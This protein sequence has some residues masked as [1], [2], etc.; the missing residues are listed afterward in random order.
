MTGQEIVDK[1]KFYTDYPANAS[2]SEA[3]AMANEVYNEILRDRDWAFLNKTH[4][5]TVP[6]VL[7]YSVDL[8]TDF[9][10]TVPNWEDGREYVLIGDDL[11]PYYIVSYQDRNQYKDLTGYTYI[12][13]RQGKLFFTG[14][15]ETADTMVFDYIYQPDDIELATSP[16]FDS[17]FHMAIVWGMIPRFNIADGTEKS[18]A[19]YPESEFKYENTLSEMRLK[20]ARIKERI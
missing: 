6:I 8:P 3:L 18:R 2:D 20:D 10:L 1:F 14:T 15:P 9:Y 4:S 17:K 11:A 12:D 19:Y 5:A 16:V 7:P 13:S